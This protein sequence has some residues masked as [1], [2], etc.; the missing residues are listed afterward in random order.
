MART[1]CYWGASRK[2]DVWDD[3]MCVCVYVCRNFFIIISSHITWVHCNLVLVH[4]FLQSLTPL[5]ILALLYC[6]DHWPSP[7]SKHGYRCILASSLRNQFSLATSP[8]WAVHCPETAIAELTYSLWVQQE[9][10]LHSLNH[11]LNWVCG[12]GHLSFPWTGSFT[13]FLM[14]FSF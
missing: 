9:V 1:S 2:L 6:S 14:M 3:T 12:S 8:V 10:L 5:I 7:I 11:S 4:G 13:P